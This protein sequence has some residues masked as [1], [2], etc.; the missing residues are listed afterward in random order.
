MEQDAR[1]DL[2][3]VNRPDELDG[4]DVV[5]LPGSKSVMADLEA[6]RETGMADALVTCHENGGRLVGICGGYQMLG[7]RILDPEGVESACSEM[8]GLGLLDVVT[9]LTGE[10]QTHQVEGAPLPVAKDVGL[11][12]LDRVSGYEIHMGESILGADARPL[13][14][15]TKRSGQVIDLLDGAVSPDHRVW[16]TYLH[17]L[18]DDPDLKEALLAAWGVTNDGPRAKVAPNELDRELD[19]LADHLAAHL[20]TEKIWALLGVVGD[21][22]G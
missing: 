18:F 10:K 13:F 22:T 15:L 6:L 1:I 12:G 4:L 11:L 20:D 16:G 3:Y 17:G 7:R 19:R 5:I 8:S 21:A 9:T 2:R 14:R